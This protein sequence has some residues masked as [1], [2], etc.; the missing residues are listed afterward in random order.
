M[1]MIRENIGRKFQ[2]SAYFPKVH[3]LMRVTVPS[4]STKQTS[5]S[6]IEHQ[7]FR[8]KVNAVPLQ[9]I[10]L[11]EFSGRGN[12]GFQTGW[13]GRADISAAAL[14]RQRK[15]WPCS[16]EAERGWEGDEGSAEQS[17]AE[18]HWSMHARDPVLPT[19][20]T[21]PRAHSWNHPFFELPF[22]LL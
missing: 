4:S 21:R 1:V 20:A 6:I 5:I 16:P 10:T 11:W 15:P 8:W 9:H 7:V 19:S 13:Q 2:I 14:A 3:S 22:S 12:W 17:R 18:V